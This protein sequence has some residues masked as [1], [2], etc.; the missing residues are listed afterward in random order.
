MMEAS[1]S[2]VVAAERPKTGGSSIGLGALRNREFALF[3]SGQA[4]SQTGTWM[5]QFAQGWVVAT[6]ASSAL[7]AHTSGADRRENLVWPEARTSGER[8]TALNDSISHSVHQT[9][10]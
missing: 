5:Q 3:W 7:L 8:H 2:R 6:L 9:R 4:I 1:E 10:L